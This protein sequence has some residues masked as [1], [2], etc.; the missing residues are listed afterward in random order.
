MNRILIVEPDAAIRQR[1]RGWLE[2]SGYA[3]IDAASAAEAADAFGPLAHLAG[4]IANA[5]LHDEL[6]TV[7]QQVPVIL[8]AANPTVSQAVQ[9]MKRGAVNYLELPGT[10]AELISSLIADLAHAVSSAASDRS[11]MI[12]ACAPM[13]TLIE[14]IAKVAP[15]ESPVL[16]RGESGTGKELLARALH[17]GSRRRLAP[18]ICVNCAAIPSH[19]I[20][21]ELFG[22]A[23]SS[24]SPRRG[25]LEAAASG[26]LFLDEIGE[27]PLETQARLLQVLESSG[28]GG[29]PV[30]DVRL[31]AATQ[32]DLEQLI[33]SD[34]FRNDL[35]YRLNVVSLS[36]P[37]LRERG[38]DVLLLA[39]AILERTITR[40][41]GTMLEFSS[42]ATRAMCRYSWPGNVRELE[43]AIE[44]AVILC[45]GDT[46][47]TDLLA[48]DTSKAL[49][50][51]AMPYTPE[52][53]MEDYFV[54]FVTA[55]Q[56]Q[57]TETELAERLGISRKS[58]WER[59]QRL[60]IPRKKTR[61]RGPRR[62][63]H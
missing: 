12:G 30:F 59:R 28:Q 25:L 26:T 53:T 23:D 17:A 50:V 44:R 39:D 32:R 31:I 22:H 34:Q 7:T 41:G 63:I 35:Y 37:P 49:P 18:L 14:G 61:K 60:S 9:A 54:S 13:R 58:L 8:L 62:E 52:Q 55:H 47:G 45:D 19:L 10:G 29:L 24:D 46:I 57:L 11:V 27:L 16:I 38:E 21:A 43:N 56:D 6:L 36:L 1:I 51:D 5:D 15:T 33:S 4:I 40:M 20:D 2:E 48:I 3:A 42:E